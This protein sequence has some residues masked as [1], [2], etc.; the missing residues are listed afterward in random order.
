MSS[1]LPP[2]VKRVRTKWTQEHAFR[3]FT[4]DIGTWWPLGTHSV[5]Q[6]RATGVRME[7]RVG[8]RIIESMQGGEEATWGT[9]SAWDPPRSVSF[10]WHPGQPVEDAQRVTVRVEPDGD[11][12]V[13]TLTHE[14]WEKLGDR[15]AKARKAYDMGWA[16]VL[17]LWQGKRWHPLVL[18]MNVTL[19]VLGP[20]L[21]RRFEKEQKLAAE[22]RA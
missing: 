7:P 2:V 22:R 20:L 21:R 9:L 3:R 14:G 6:H 16:P 13:L 5:G 12:S 1:P 4:E 18:F 11:G 15:A 19:F 10:T 17:L 8:G